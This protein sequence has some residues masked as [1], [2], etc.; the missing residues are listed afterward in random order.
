MTKLE[1]EYKKLFN[2]YKK[3]STTKKVNIEFDEVKIKP[4]P[5]KVDLE[6][7][8][9]NINLYFSEDFFSDI[10]DYI[11]GKIYTQIEDKAKI[12]QEKYLKEVKEFENK[13]RIYCEKTNQEFYEVYDNLDK[14]YVDLLNSKNK[15]NLLKKK[16]EQLNK[17]LMEINKQLTK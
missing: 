14:E 17:E 6:W 11:Y 3:L 10:N 4:T 13:L 1:K 2:E 15:K 5:L 9:P 16:K 12:H 8:D 7:E